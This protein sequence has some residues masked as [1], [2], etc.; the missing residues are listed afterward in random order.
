MPN[1]KPRSN[2][3]TG[4]DETGALIN[5]FLDDYNAITNLINNEIDKY[6]G[7]INEKTGLY[8]KKIL[9]IVDTIPIINELI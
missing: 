3:G 1:T 7:Y 6:R 8:K 2:C 4:N 5:S 9:D